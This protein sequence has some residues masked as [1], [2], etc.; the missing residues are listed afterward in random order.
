[1]MTSNWSTLVTLSGIRCSD[2]SGPAEYIVGDARLRRKDRERIKV[3]AVGALGGYRIQWSS[4]TGNNVGMI[5]TIFRSRGGGG[6]SHRV[7]R[8]SYS[9]GVI[10]LV[11]LGKRC[12][13]MWLSA[14][15]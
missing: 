12:L 7:C 8:L 13:L 5:V 11:L 4:F 3:F 9:S 14:G 2:R 6:G 10:V 1:M 15:R